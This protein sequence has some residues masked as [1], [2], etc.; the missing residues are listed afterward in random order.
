MTIYIY[1]HSCP[2]S[3]GLTNQ[4]IMLIAAIRFVDKQRREDEFCGFGIGCFYKDI[5]DQ[6][7]ITS[8]NEIMD[9]SILSDYFPSIRFFD[10][11]ERHSKNLKIQTKPGEL[12]SLQEI[13]NRK[14]CPCSIYK[15]ENQVFE[16]KNRIV[17]KLKS[18]HPWDLDSPQ[19]VSLMRHFSFKISVKVLNVEATDECIH[20]LHL[21]NERDA[22]KWWSKQNG[23]SENIF[24]QSLNKKFIQCVKIF[25]PKTEKL[26]VITGRVV[27]NPVLVELSQDGYNILQCLKTYEE[28]EMSALEDLS[29]AERHARNGIFIGCKRGSTFSSCLL[30]PRIPFKKSVHLDLDN[31]KSTVLICEKEMT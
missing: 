18:H 21:R 7:K 6:K 28:R 30:E 29:F 12:F 16:W 4:L 19:V 25:I 11:H 10:Y 26:I 24:E 13:I 8:F 27:N 15:E 2:I 9:L 20:L 31:I 3:R 22:I 17:T 5:R 1:E 23:M 14:P